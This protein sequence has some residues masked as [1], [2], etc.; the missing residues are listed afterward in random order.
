VVKWVLLASLYQYKR[1][2]THTD[3]PSPDTHTHT[4][5]S[6]RE[7]ERLL[8][9]TPLSSLNLSPCDFLVSEGGIEA[10]RKKRYSGVFEIQQT[11][12]Q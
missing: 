2:P 3:P 9:S 1:A 6:K 4:H 11:T 12:H 7:R 5:T 10:E 8:S